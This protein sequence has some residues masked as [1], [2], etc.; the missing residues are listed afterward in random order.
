MA[1][2]IKKDGEVVIKK[3][4]NPTPAP[5]AAV[6]E[7]K[8]QRDYKAEAEAL[9]KELSQAQHTIVTL[10][11]K[12]KDD[13]KQPNDQNQN[14]V[15]TPDVL[16]QT[17]ENFKIEQ[18]SEI[19]NDELSKLTDN[20]DKQAL[21]KLTY[22]K[23]IMKGGFTRASIQAD[24]ASAL[25]IVDRPRQEKTIE[26][27]KKRNISDITKNKS[28]NVAG[29]DITSNSGGTTEDMLTPKDRVIMARHGLTLEDINKGIKK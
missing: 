29:Q 24:L 27:L 16:N 6:G 23:K 11:K 17:L 19:F 14:G 2:E 26:E 10:K 13:D 21:I 3:D 9:A 7:E 18:S 25:A 4:D 12:D 15:V 28:G 22:E 20:P 8:D 1:D 5:A